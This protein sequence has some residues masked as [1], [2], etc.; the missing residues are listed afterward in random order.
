MQADVP[1]ETSRNRR[2]AGWLFAVSAAAYLVI[3]SETVYVTEPFR[4][5]LLNNPPEF[6]VV[7]IALC[8]PV[9]A[10]AVC[11]VLL[12]GTSGHSVGINWLVLAIGTTTCGWLLLERWGLFIV[13]LLAPTALFAT[14]AYRKEV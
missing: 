8:T 10:C 13:P 3:L 2:H 5:G 11:A 12:L 4:F 14:R 6:I 1:I 7:L 9:I